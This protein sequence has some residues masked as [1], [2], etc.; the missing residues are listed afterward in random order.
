MYNG[1]MPHERKRYLSE[2]LKSVLNVSPIVGILGHRQVGK[3]TLLMQHCS[4][5]FSLDDRDT[6]DKIESNPKNFLKN[7]HKLKVGLDESQLLPEL[8]T[9]LKEQV[10]TDKRPGQF[11]LSGSVRFTSRRA[12]RESLTGRIMN[13]ELLPMSM[14]EIKNLPLSNAV[15]KI[16]TTDSLLKLDDYFEIESKRRMSLFAQIDESIERGGLP[17][18]CFIRNKKLAENKIAEQLSTILDRDIRQIYPTS[19]SYTQ[20]LD[21][22]REL[23]KIEGRPLQFSKIKAQTKLQESTQKKLLY[24][25]ESVFLIR[26]MPIE[27]GRKGMTL[28]FEDQAESHYLSLRKSNSKE[29]WTGLCYRNIRVP[30]FY[31]LGKNYRYFS[32]LTKGKSNV[33]FA[34]QSPSGILGF[35]P[36]EGDRPEH[37]DQIHANS[38]LK[39]YA[40]SKIIYVCKSKK[41]E[42]MSDRIAILP[43]VVF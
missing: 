2:L 9:A 4:Q 3:T 32:F 29:S 30:L 42:I 31:E 27:G 16:L 12:I 13:L 14:S 35:I 15:D 26:P 25:L 40:N 38:F 36:I 21:F 37:A 22:V 17:G 10:R 24:A 8:F 41:I 28:F 34:V 5:Y 18:V 7:H 39:H 23:S 19:L 43:L 20:I 6:F 1:Y 33:P 11:I